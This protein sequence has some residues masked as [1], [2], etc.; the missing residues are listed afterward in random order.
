[1][2]CIYELVDNGWNL[3]FGC[4]FGAFTNYDGEIP[5]VLY[6]LYV[7][8][9]NYLCNMCVVTIIFFCG[10][11]VSTVVQQAATSDSTVILTR[12][13]NGKYQWSSLQTIETS[14]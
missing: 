11:I 13:H 1:M 2:I 8:V 9:N 3:E 12:V 7:L 6:R 4:G 14:S 10:V 5:S